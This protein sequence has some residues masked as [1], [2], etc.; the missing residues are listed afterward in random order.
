MKPSDEFDNKPVRDIKTP[1]SRIQEF[2]LFG[3]IV[4]CIGS[5]LI[6]NTS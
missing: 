3:P 5:V 4:L 6:A 1:K 2:K